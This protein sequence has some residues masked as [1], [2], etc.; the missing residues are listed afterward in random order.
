MRAFSTRIC[1]HTF[2][3][4][5]KIVNSR[6]VRDDERKYIFISFLYPF[7]VLF[8]FL[9]YCVPIPFSFFLSI[10]IPL[11]FF[12]RCSSRHKISFASVSLLIYSFYTIITFL[13][14]FYICS[15][16]YTFSP[17]GLSRLQIEHLVLPEYV[18][19]YPQQ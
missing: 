14:L 16:Y 19:S 10:I 7:F 1:R 13:H 6:L 15:P 3:V 17:H 4:P 9:L 2:Q 8:L 11:P 12:P 5:L 18:R